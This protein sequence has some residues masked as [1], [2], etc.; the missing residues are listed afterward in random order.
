MKHLLFTTVIL[1]FS[2]LI[3][4][5]ALVDPIEF[6]VLTEEVRGELSATRMVLGKSANGNDLAVYVLTS[7]AS[8]RQK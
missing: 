1:I 6:D 7:S 2:L 8:P 5:R 3:S 4:S